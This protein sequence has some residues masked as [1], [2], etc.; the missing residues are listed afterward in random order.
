MPSVETRTRGSS[1][2]IIMR[3][4]DKHLEQHT[5]IIPTKHAIKGNHMCYLLKRFDT[6]LSCKI[7]AWNSS[8]VTLMTKPSSP[9]R[10]RSA[11]HQHHL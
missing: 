6:A 8:F 11:V 1:K 4:L 9:R 3:V 7:G 10:S 2:H 5:M